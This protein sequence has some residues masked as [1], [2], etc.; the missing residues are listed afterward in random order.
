MYISI[1][2]QNA[3]V[4]YLTGIQVMFSL[5]QCVIVDIPIGVPTP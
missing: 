4:I 1:T 5:S 2:D 3:Y